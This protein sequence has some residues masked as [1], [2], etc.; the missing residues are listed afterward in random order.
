MLF[1]EI[2]Q[3]V[4]GNILIKL[5]FFRVI[6]GPAVLN[7]PNF[8]LVQD[9][10]KCGNNKI[11]MN[12]QCVSVSVLPPLKCPGTVDNVICSGRGVSK[13]HCT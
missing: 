9:G 13:I 6:H 4:V 3:G 8:G 2:I 5:Y 10:S 12:K 1:L 7:L 11:C